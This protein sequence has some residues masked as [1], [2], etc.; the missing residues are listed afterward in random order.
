MSGTSPKRE[1]WR[2]AAGR[3]KAALVLAPALALGL[4]GCVDVRRA[5]APEG[6]NVE[7]PV[8]PAA[9]AASRAAL[10]TPRFSEVP[11]VP[12]DVPPAP[13]FKARVAAEAVQGRRLEGWVAEHPP[14]TSDTDAFADR[15]RRQASKGGDAPAED[16]SAAAEAFAARVR[17]V[18][19]PPPPPG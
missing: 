6:V 1:R 9:L 10:R 13:V 5:L 17:A 8:A 7:S 12:Q 4:S 16:R 2:A 3:A 15:G 11:P 14:Y 18:A 19:K